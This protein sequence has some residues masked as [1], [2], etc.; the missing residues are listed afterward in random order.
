[1]RRASAVAGVGVAGTGWRLW[2]ACLERGDGSLVL[3]LTPSSAWGA[4][5]SGRPVAIGSPGPV[6]PA[7][8]SAGAKM[9]IDHRERR[10]ALRSQPE[11]QELSL[12]IIVSV[13]Q[14]LY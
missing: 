5:G 9:K 4:G 13:T 3:G 8:R 1:M 7:A 11:S 10:R 14:L 12:I 2:G 6:G